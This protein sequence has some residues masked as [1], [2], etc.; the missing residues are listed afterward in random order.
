[1]LCHVPSEQLLAFSE[2]IC[3]WVL[4]NRNAMESKIELKVMSAAT[5]GV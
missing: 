1:M 3:R 5:R 2:K 4:F